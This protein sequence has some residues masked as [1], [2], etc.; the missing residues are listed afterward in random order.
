VINTLKGFLDDIRI[1]DLSIPFT[2][3]AADI[4]TEKEVW[5]NSGS[6]FDA[7][8]ASASLPLFFTPV[9]KGDAVLIDGGVLNPV[10][11]APTLND[12]TELTIAVNLGGPALPEE[13]ET[14]EA[15]FPNEDTSELK[16]QLKKFISSLGIETEESHKKNWSM[17]E[18]ADK[19]FDTMQGAIAKMKIASYS[20]DIEIEI[21]RNA[22]G[23]FDF[24]RSA[25]MIKLGYNKAQSVFEATSGV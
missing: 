18:V 19:A 23:T 15:I 5:I 12:E 16:S 3:V 25:Q 4:V 11:I 8:R 1:E 10:P 13:E 2:A 24:H 17:Y 7:I 14:P 6:L 9:E 20:P 22:C 21:A